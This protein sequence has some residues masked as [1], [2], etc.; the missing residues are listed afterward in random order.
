MIKTDFE[1]RFSCDL[2]PPGDFTLYLGHGEGQSLSHQTVTEVRAGETTQVQ[3]GGTGRRVTGKLA[4]S[5]GTNVDWSTQLISASLSSN[6][7]KPITQPPHEATSTEN[8]AGKLKLL[9]FF[10]DSQ[11]WRAYERSSGS[12]PLQVAADGTFTAEGIPPGPY[13]LNASLAES[14]SIGNSPDP[15]ARFQRKIFATLR[16]EIVIPESIDES[17]PFDLGTFTAKSS[18]AA[19]K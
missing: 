3:I 18:L 14:P 8:V 12:Y 7:Q 4:M 16:Q 1:G 13:L 2:V 17:I 6:Q 15:I 5:D 19:R 10:D 11:E 9:D